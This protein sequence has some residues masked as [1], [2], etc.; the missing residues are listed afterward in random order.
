MFEPRGKKNW[1]C[2]TSGKFITPFPVSLGAETKKG[3]PPQRSMRQS[4]LPYAAPGR[5]GELN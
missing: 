3:R 2:L 4:G 5:T 1:N